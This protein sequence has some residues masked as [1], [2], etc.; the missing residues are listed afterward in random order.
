MVGRGHVMTPAARNAAH[1]LR[2]LL[3]V[4]PFDYWRFP[5]IEFGIDEVTVVLL[6]LSDRLHNFGF[7][8]WWELALDMLNEFVERTGLDSVFGPATVADRLPAGYTHGYMLGDDPSFYLRCAYNEDS[9]RMGAIVRVSAAAFGLYV[10]RSG[11]HL[12]KFLQLA[13]SPDS[14]EVRAS[15]VD[16]TADFI[17]VDELANADTLYRSLYHGSVVGMRQQF[18]KKTGSVSLRRIPKVSGAFVGTGDLVQTFYIGSKAATGKMLFRC[19][20]K[21]AEQ[22]ERSGIHVA[23][24]ASCNSWVRFEVS[25]RHEYADQFCTALMGC[26]SDAEEA[27]TVAT[28]FEQKYQFFEVVDGTLSGRTAWSDDMSACAASGS[29]ILS[30][31]SVRVGDLTHS[32]K[33]LREGSGLYTVLYK[34]REIW[35]DDAPAD[36]MAFLLDDFSRNYYPSIEHASWVKTRAKNLRAA[37]P[38][39]GSWLNDV[40]SAFSAA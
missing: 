14:Y 6:P 35:G 40:S 3:L 11:N 38:D 31:P 27:T 18:D 39:V 33:H 19:Y 26:C 1:F 29:P 37:Y 12:H 23:K 21:R 4:Y 25:L 13:Y 9:P 5:V 30:S 2:Y 28:V 22:L 32:M 8:R 16:V 10:E 34:A 36:V 24:A 15:R 7:E 17:D 20:D